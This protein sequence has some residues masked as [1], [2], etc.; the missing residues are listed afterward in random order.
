MAPGNGDESGP[1]CKRPR[2]LSNT[3]SNLT[4]GENS[5]DAPSEALGPAIPR[6]SK[7]TEISSRYSK[8]FRFVMQDKKPT[9]ICLEC[10]KKNVNK[11]LMRSG[12]NTSG[13]RKHLKCFH[14]SVYNKE[15]GNG[16]QSTLDFDQKTVKEMFKPVNK[17][18]YI[19]VKLIMI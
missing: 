8:Y 9:A 15:F 11:V 12:G 19:F 14:Y 1:P 4:T 2:I 10:K 17:L 5:G 13:L 6:S 16:E 18:S 3:A 7:D